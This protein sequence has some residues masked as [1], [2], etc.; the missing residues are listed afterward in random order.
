MDKLPGRTMDEYDSFHQSGLAK[1]KGEK[2]DPFDP[3]DSPGSE[4]DDRSVKVKSR[5]DKK[6]AKKPADST[7]SSA[8]PLLSGAPW[9]RAEGGGRRRDASDSDHSEI[10]EG[11]IVVVDRREGNDRV[12]SPTPFCVSKPERILRVLDGDGLV[13]VRTEGDDAWAD[14]EPVV[15]VE[16][17]RNKLLSRQKERFSS[18]PALSPLP[19][20]PLLLPSHSSAGASSRLSPLPGDG[21]QNPAFQGSD[22]GD[23]QKEADRKGGERREKKTKRKKDK[24]GQERGKDKEKGKK[25]D[26]KTRHS[27]S[28]ATKKKSHSKETSKPAKTSHKRDHKSSSSQYE[29]RDADRGRS[30]VK[31]KTREGYKERERPRERERGRERSRDV[32]RRPSRSRSHRRHIGGGPATPHKDKER[33]E[34]KHSSSRKTETSSRRSKTSREP[35]ASR[36][37]GRGEREKRRDGRPVIPP[38]IQDLSGS[39]LFA[40]KRTITVTTTTTTTTAVPGSPPPYARPV[41][42]PSRHR[43]RKWLSAEDEDVG[44]EGRR[45]PSLSPPRFP[46]YQSQHYDKFEIDV[47]SLDGEALDSDYQLL[48]DT[49]PAGLPPD[50]EV[51]APQTKPAPKATRRH[52]KKKAKEVD[53]YEASSLS[54]SKSKTKHL[55]SLKVTSGSASVPGLPGLASLKRSKKTRKN[56]EQ[57]KTSRKDP[58]RSG[59]SKK[60]EGSNRK[61]KLQSKVSVLVRDGVSSTTGGKPGLD[62]L[63]SA[64]PPGASVVGDSIAV[65][66]CRDNESRSPFLKPCSEPLASARLAAPLPSLASPAG[67]LKSKKAKPSSIT[68]TSSS[69]SS[70]SLVLTNKRCRRLARKTKVKAGVSGSTDDAVNAPPKGSSE[71]WERAS[72]DVQSGTGDVNDSASPRPGQTGVVP[73]SSSSSSSSST[74]STNNALAPSSS[75]HRTPPPADTR[76]RESSSPD[77]QTVDSSCKTPETSFLADEG[78]T[79]TSPRPPGPAAS[80]SSSSSVQGGGPASAPN[81]RSPP[82]DQETKASSSPSNL[83][84]STSGDLST[85]SSLPKT[86]SEPPASVSSSSVA[87]PFLPSPFPW[88][89]QTGVDCAA[90][91]VLARKSPRPRSRLSGSYRNR[92]IRR[93]F[94]RLLLK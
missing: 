60:E 38:S 40:I 43:K 45:S 71:N 4:V 67:G 37:N 88:N 80:P 81:A 28:G 44:K 65:V 82:G 34:R 12:A 53:Q 36:S 31:D 58:S 17:L 86:S 5:S 22:D 84:S 19:L 87:K 29:D 78:P 62:L 54:S 49:P 46:S 72:S 51:P 42:E 91:G 32:E 57:D 77:S 75:P 48:D 47:L 92:P 2:Y 33:K 69:A 11:E 1:I 61:G 15:G 41:Q 63:G 89:L 76:T 30:I 7:Q 3:T 64:G 73:G 90:G 10:E 74:S 68:S 18:L 59:K 23:P 14:E 9:W 85:F 52:Q 39:D 66:F 55:S 79:Q 25:E 94:H 8:G 56:K 26:K 16:D 93:Q 13:S 6:R 83:S 27:S 50:P 70:S 20:Q 35:R 24:G 21:V